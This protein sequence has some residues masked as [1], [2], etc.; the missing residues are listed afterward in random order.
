M[1]PTREQSPTSSDAPTPATPAARAG[2]IQRLGIQGKL[3]FAFGF[4][5]FVG[6][7]ASCWL[8]AYQ[9][10][11]RLEDIMGEQARQI[12]FALA[13]ASKPSLEAGEVGE[14]RQISQDLLK[15]R[16]ILFVAFMDKNGR[17]LTLSSRDPD[18]GWDHLPF[19]K[20][21]TSALMRVY[22]ESRPVL[23]NYSVVTAPV[24]NVA[25]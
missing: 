13:L 1:P 9:S 3:I 15:S 21:R 11:L 18:F 23:G 7:A 20:D 5:M 2:V 8:F 14:L 12:S 17:P 16:N 19:L 10:R 6:L 24:L 4:V 25:S 22:Q